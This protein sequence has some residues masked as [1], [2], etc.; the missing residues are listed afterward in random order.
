MCGRYTL[1]KPGDALT[2]MGEIDTTLA[3][4]FDASGP[5][6]RV[7]EARWNI[8]PTQSVLV[9]RPQRQEPTALEAMA[10]RWGLIP[11]WAKKIGKPL[12]NA[13]SETVATTA[14]FRDSYKKRR[15]L[16]AADGFY[17]WGPSDLGRQPH[18]FRKSGG[19]PFWFAGIWS[20][21][22][23]PESQLT[24]GIGPQKV[25]SCAVLTTEANAVLEGVHDRMPVILGNDQARRWIE[26]DTGADEL[27]ALCRP[28]DPAAMEVWPVG[29]AVNKVANEGAALL[30]PAEPESE[31]LTLF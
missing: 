24:E 19:P 15:C 25:R 21:W 4:D 14:S 12:I 11:H 27:A 22:S 13:R 20:I 29:R 17:E 26:A 31:N 2:G 9:L 5:R 16:V 10:M 8:A 28:L 3:E 1:T 7:L 18:Y 30:D 6:E 23:P